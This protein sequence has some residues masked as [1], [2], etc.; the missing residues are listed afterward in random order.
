MA[1]TLYLIELSTAG[2][3]GMAE[4]PAG[5]GF[6]DSALVGAFAGAFSGDFAGA[7]VLAVDFAGAGAAGVECR[8]T[9]MVRMVGDDW[10][11]AINSRQSGQA[12]MGIAKW[13]G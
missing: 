8:A 5:L 7:G 6:L 13:D 10:Q 3:T 9:G 4:E 2:T 1:W 11:P 12:R